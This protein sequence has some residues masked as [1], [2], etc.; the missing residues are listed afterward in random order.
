MKAG[1]AARGVA[2]ACAVIGLVG[3]GAG[4]AAAQTPI[5]P[6]QHFAGVVN[7]VEGPVVVNTVCP[8]PAGRHR[9]GPVQGGQAMLVV[10]VPRGHGD[11]GVF[12]QVYAWFEPVR[13]GTRPVALTFKQYGRPRDIPRAVRVPCTGTGEAVFSSCPYLAPCA[14]GFVQ[15]RLK[16][17][18]EN[19]AVQPT[20]NDHQLRYRTG[21]H[22]TGAR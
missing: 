8:G 22:R 2:A 6:H 14:A 11:T 18:F 15:D 19:V 20:R 16:V 12:S 17:K 9:T 13:H 3:A 21:L 5:G 10:E 4:T 7:G 1:L